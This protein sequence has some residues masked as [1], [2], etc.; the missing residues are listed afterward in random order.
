MQIW[1]LRQPG[2]IENSTFNLVKN[3][4]P[5]PKSLTEIAKPKS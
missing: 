2:L 3:V 4:V 5:F 1:V